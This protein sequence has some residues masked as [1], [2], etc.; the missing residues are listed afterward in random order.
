[1]K[2]RILC[3]LTVVSLF[4]RALPA[5]S[6]PPG[7]DESIWDMPNPKDCG[8]ITRLAGNKI[9][10]IS[11]G[12]LQSVNN[13]Y[14]DDDWAL[15]RRKGQSLYNVTAIN[16]GA[17]IGTV[18]GL[19]PFFGTDGTN[20]L[21]AFSSGQ[22]WQSNGNGAWTAIPG[23]NNLTASA[24]MQCSQA[25]GSL[26][27][28]DG[29]DPVFFWNGS[30]TGTVASAPQGT[31]ISAFQNRLWIAGVSGNLTQLYGS[32][33]LNGQDWALNLYPS[34]STSSVIIDI[35]GANDGQKITCLMGEFQGKF[36]IGRTYETYAL[37]GS[38]N[39][40]WTI[41]RFSDQIGCIEPKSIQ[42]VNNALYWLSKR[43]IEQLTG[44]QIN[45][46]SYYIRPDVDVI[47]SAAG[48]GVSKKLFTQSDWQSGQLKASGPGA[49]ISATISPGN[50][51][52]STWTISEST[53]Q[54]TLGTLN[55]LSTNVVSGAMSFAQSTFSFTN[56]SL[57]AGNLSNWN[58]ISGTFNSGTNLGAFCNNQDCAISSCGDR[59]N[60]IDTASG[61]MNPS[62]G[63]GT[64]SIKIDVWSGLVR[65]PRV[66]LKECTF[67]LDNNET[68]C[69]LTT[70][71]DVGYSTGPFMTAG[72]AHPW[73]YWYELG[74][75]ISTFSNTPLDIGI[76]NGASGQIA[77]DQIVS[78]VSISDTSQYA[79]FATLAQC[80]GTPGTTS[81]RGTRSCGVTNYVYSSTFT[82][83]AYDTAFS[84]P[85]WGLVSVSTV[86]D[87][88]SSFSFGT[89]VSTSS[90][91]V[92]DST[93]AANA[94]NQYQI[95]SAKKE[96]IR[97]SLNITHV[98]GPN[99]YCSTCNAS[100]SLVTL[101]AN[102]TAYYVTPCVEV[103]TPTSW[104]NLAVDGTQ[105][106]GSFTFWTSTGNTCNAAITSTVTWN[107]QTAN[108]P[109]SVS[110]ATKFIAE[111]ILFNVDVGTETPIIQDMTFNWNTGTTRPPVSSAQYLDRYY[112]FYT[113]STVSGNHNDHALVYDFNG[114]WTRLDDTNA[115]S[116]ALYLNHLYLGDS[117]STGNVYE[118]DQGY[119]D[120]GGQYTTSFQ[121]ADLDFGNPAQLKIMERMYL[122]LNFNPTSASHISMTCNYVID[123]STTSYLLG[124]SFLSENPEASGYYVAKY[125]FPVAN[126]AQ[127]HWIN[128]SCSY[129][130][131]DGPIE[132]YG[133]K[134]I[135]K[136]ASWD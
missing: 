52:V 126:P 113:T 43:G 73:M 4:S 36:L 122:F 117:N 90:T 115:Y 116:A 28:T 111:R 100:V 6:Q 70:N 1:M 30:S 8:L 69:T 129:F 108:A 34:L 71:C 65:G 46:V 56:G 103:D 44:T 77:Y 26:W 41:Y 39:R 63:Y 130:G 31:L 104:G 9:G 120:N 121:T 118:M 12:C 24:E 11:E 79:V 68:P 107:A 40:D 3:L 85:T 60:G 112:M 47:I 22:M 133:M 54:F 78:S 88:N 99:N 64:A 32:G 20:Y 72:I 119:N 91:G 81:I 51:Q 96:F 35:G 94:A 132:V 136:K 124:T 97:Y 62:A 48:N 27:C 84:T 128:F 76:D 59:S 106:G 23:T 86:N 66:K 55:Q 49:P 17:G 89:Q 10:G 101:N 98:G 33:F 2:W 125:A 15:K 7:Q 53:T 87:G 57:T 109:I 83:Q 127:A 5:F 29:S 37:A 105:N 13:A 19:W 25:F 134:V 95:G 75:N 42:E 114:R 50:I 123:G 61:Y 82:S 74:I 92:F 93:V 14:Y 58:N 131:S 110:T 18:K 21:V 45:P 80:G 38:S 67:S 16:S 135:Y 102:T